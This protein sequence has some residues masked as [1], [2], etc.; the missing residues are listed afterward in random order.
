[1]FDS[2]EGGATGTWQLYHFYFV[3][4]KELIKSSTAETP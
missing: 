2:L 3:A 1:M 4:S